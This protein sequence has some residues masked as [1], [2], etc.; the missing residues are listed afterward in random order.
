MMIIPA[1][2]L[3]FA[4]VSCAIAANCPNGQPSTG[5]CAPGCPP[6]STCDQQIMECC[7]TSS[8]LSTNV[9]TN[10]NTNTSTNISTLLMSN[11]STSLKPQTATTKLPFRTSPVPPKPGK[12]VD[13]VN[14]KTKFADCVFRRHL[15]DQPIYRKVM[16]EQCPR[17]CKRCNEVPPSSGGCVDHINPETKKSDCQERKEQCKD[18]MYLTVMKAQCPKTCG[19]CDTTGNKAAGAGQKVSGG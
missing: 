17:T 1:L 5:P 9:S 16:T 4:L 18:P 19:F 8:N 10:I 13:K 2:L 7:P 14:P 15:C 11:G 12:C 6:G 3:E